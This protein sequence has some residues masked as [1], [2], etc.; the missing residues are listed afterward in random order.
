MAIPSTKKSKLPPTFPDH[1]TA[2]TYFYRYSGFVLFA[3]EVDRESFS[4]LQQLYLLPAGKSYRE[5]LRDYFAQWKV[6][7]RRATSE[8]L[9]LIF[10]TM[11]EP[12]GAVSAVRSA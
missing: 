1:S 4:E 10:S 7:G 9:E 5:D 12:Q 3:K 11:K 8:D 6:A 2:Y